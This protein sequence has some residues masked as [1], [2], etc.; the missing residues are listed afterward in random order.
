MT[1]QGEEFDWN[2]VIEA[3]VNAFEATFATTKKVTRTLYITQKFF[4]TRFIS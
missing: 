1:Q 3:F 2:R 4:L